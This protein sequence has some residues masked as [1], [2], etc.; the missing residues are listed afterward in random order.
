MATTATSSSP[1]SARAG[2]GNGYNAATGE[3]GDL[4]A[5][6][7]LDPV[8]VT[9]SALVNATSIAG[10]LLTTETLIVE[11][12]EDEEPRGGRSR[13][14]SRPLSHGP[15][16]TWSCRADAFT[17]RNDFA[18]GETC[19]QE[20][21]L[22]SKPEPSAVRLGGGPV[23][24]AEQPDGGRRRRCPRGRSAPSPAA[25]KPALPSPS[26]C[27]KP[28]HST[29]HVGG[30]SAPTSAESS[31]RSGS[32]VAHRAGS[33][34]RRTATPGRSPARGRRGRRTRP[35]CRRARPRRAARRRCRSRSAAP[36]RWR[37]WPP[38]RPSRPRSR[39]GGQQHRHPHHPAAHRRGAWPA[40][41]HRAT[42]EGTTANR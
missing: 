40:A 35:G 12:P 32:R 25:S 3:Y 15:H 9:R 29:I 6:G 14:R 11:K 21:E 17:R 42:T 16:R 2:V 23:D 22:N 20:P 24:A 30:G 18:P 5:Q 33:T 38:S 39:H 4:V 10:M 36:R 26:Q 34:G 1:R 19:C 8:K 41:P 28:T 27:R 13:P 37:C 7:V 31:A